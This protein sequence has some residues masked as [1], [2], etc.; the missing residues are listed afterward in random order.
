MMQ[1]LRP[2]YFQDHRFIQLPLSV[3]FLAI[4]LL[5]T[6]QAHAGFVEIGGS[7]GL[8]KTTIDEG[9]YE[10][11]QSETG[12]V[13]YYFDESSALELSYTN[14]YTKQ[15]FNESLPGG[16]VTTMFYS[17]AGL[18]FIYTFGTRET[19]FRPYLKV[20]TNY[21][22]DKRIVDQYRGTDGNWNPAHTEPVAPTFVPSAGA[23]F[24]IG[25]SENLSLKVG[26]DAW[27]SAAVSARPINIDYAGRAGISF[28]F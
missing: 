4:I 11:S 28:M 9:A 16:H 27:T 18:D 24:R 3:L 21:I 14:G 13:S 10:M 1:Q 15:A 2:R 5:T 26:V 8:K 19:R 7:F 20:G 12:S 17:M 22:I 6:A 25:I 23:G